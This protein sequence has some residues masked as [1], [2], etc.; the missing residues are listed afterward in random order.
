MKSVVIS[1]NLGDSNGMLSDWVEFADWSN[2]LK[3]HSEV[4]IYYQTSANFGY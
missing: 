3:N 2:W 4:M 1:A